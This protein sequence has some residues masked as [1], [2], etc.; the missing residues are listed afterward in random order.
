[1]NDIFF[2]KQCWNEVH[3]YL[4]VQAI[5]NNRFINN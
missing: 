3:G 2:G 4:F 5:G 1:M